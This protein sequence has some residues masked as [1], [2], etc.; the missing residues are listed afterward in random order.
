MATKI[1][2]TSSR[3]YIAPLP[4]APTFDDALLD[5]SEA[6]AE[7]E[8]EAVFES[9][10]LRKTNLT[11]AFSI[12]GTILFWP[13]CVFTLCGALGIAKYNTFCEKYPCKTAG[14]YIISIIGIVIGI[15][16][17]ILLYIYFG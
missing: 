8:A 11:F 12:I 4:S 9:K 5:D 7:A 10:L 14:A 3:F 1:P 15:S 17:W 16:E 13:I 6:E 2:V